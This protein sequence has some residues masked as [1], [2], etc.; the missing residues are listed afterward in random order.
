MS[1]ITGHETGLYARNAN[2]FSSR[3][4]TRVKLRCA[5]QMRNAV[6]KH[7]TDS[8]VADPA[9]KLHPARI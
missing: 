5:T 2:P 3:R 4:V 7:I 1:I 8:V 6:T 9:S